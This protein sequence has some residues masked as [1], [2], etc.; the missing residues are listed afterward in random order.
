MVQRAGFEASQWLEVLL[1]MRTLQACR[2]LVVFHFRL[3][4]AVF[5]WLCSEKRHDS[6]IQQA[7]SA[8]YIHGWS[9]V[10]IKVLHT[11]VMSALGNG[12]TGGRVLRAVPNATKSTWA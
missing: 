9:D 11:C 12:P 4:V 10:F 7:I 3:L 8:F 6:Y 2:W 5:G 1:V